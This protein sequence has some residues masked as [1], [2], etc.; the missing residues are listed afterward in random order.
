LSHATYST[1]LVSSDYHLF[2]FLQHTLCGQCFANVD[3]N[4]NCFDNF[5]AFKPQ[6]FVQR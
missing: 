2:R 3:D 4:K 6:S 1:D 5:I